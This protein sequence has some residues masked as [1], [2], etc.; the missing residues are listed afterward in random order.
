MPFIIARHVNTNIS[1]GMSNLPVSSRAFSVRLSSTLLLSFGLMLSILEASPRQAE[2]QQATDDKQNA[3][4][5][6]T[7]EQ[8]DANGNGAVSHSEFMNFW[9]ELFNRRDRNGDLKLSSKEAGAALVQIADNNSDDEVTWEEEQQM[10]QKHFDRMDRNQDGILTLNE[11]KPSDGRSQ[12]IPSSSGLD[13]RF[14]SQRAAVAA[15][16]NLTDAP[17]MHLA[18]GFESTDNLVAIFYEA[19]DWKEQP[20]RVFAW[21]GVPDEYEGTMP[22]I[23]LVHGG[24]GSA[25]KNWVKHW[26]ARGFAAISI[27]V[28]GQTDRKIDQKTWERHAWAGPQ[29]SGIYHD[30][31]VALA[32]QWMYHAVADTILAN[33]LIRT[34]QGVDP[35]RVGIMGISWG[36]VITSTVIG[37]DDRFAFA[38]PTYGCGDLSTAENMYGRALGENL[39]YKEVWDPMLRLETASMPTLWFSWPEDKHF[40]MDKFA[41]CYGSVAGEHMVGLVPE[42]GHGHG[43]PWGRPES[44]AFAESIVSGEGPWCR[45]IELSMQ[46][47]VASVVFDSSKKLTD[48]VLVWSRDLG[49]TGERT[50]M[51]APAKLGRAGQYWTVTATLPADCTGWFI[52]V[53]SGKLI[54]SS[55]YQEIWSSH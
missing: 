7:S 10:R 28:E 53:Q 36:G 17:T 52:N 49:V 47:N 2:F 27:A 16:S 43:P 6:K 11:N 5:I 29:R 48:A 31:D 44:Y 38:I 40:P 24:G 1:C 51:E 4:F 12:K 25:F 19:L 41:A 30:S 50:W 32:E 55:D 34:I 54:A 3:Q 8:M 37:L 42:M 15:L 39:I 14:E 22:A 35:D 13:P 21:L 45:Q 26:N 18:E 23:V 20:T 9:R 46:S 33:S